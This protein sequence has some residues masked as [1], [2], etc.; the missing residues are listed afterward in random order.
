MKASEFPGARRAAKRLR[1]RGRRRIAIRS[2][3]QVVVILGGA[4]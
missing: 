2:I 3:N 4:R 1:P